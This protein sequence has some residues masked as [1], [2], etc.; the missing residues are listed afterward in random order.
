MPKDLTDT[1]IAIVKKVAKLPTGTKKRKY[2]AEIS[3][4][5]FDANASKTERMFSRD[6]ETIE[7]G[8][9]EMVEYT[10]AFPPYGRS[11]NCP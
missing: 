10:I 5:F 8:F 9:R 11:L 6:R 1:V 3:L 2:I 4:K 7:K